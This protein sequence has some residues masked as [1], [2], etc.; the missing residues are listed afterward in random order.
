M[1]QI[2]ECLELDEFDSK[3]KIENGQINGL[4]DIKEENDYNDVSDSFDENNVS[5]EGLKKQKLIIHDI[6][7][8]SST[9]IQKYE[10]LNEK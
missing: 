5:E 8:S 9:L 2:Q 10:N 3:Y 4:K 1:I 7:C 6:H